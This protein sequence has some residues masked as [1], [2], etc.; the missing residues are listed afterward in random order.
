MSE[1]LNAEAG[2]ANKVRLFIMGQK[3]EANA[4][5]AFGQQP[6]MPYNIL[7]YPDSGANRKKS[8]GDGNFGGA[9]RGSGGNVG[10]AKKKDE[11]KRPVCF[12]LPHR[13]KEIR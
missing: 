13:E 3:E 12:H 4:F 10:D 1:R 7:E 8:G 11:N 2:L 6:K 9:C 5:L